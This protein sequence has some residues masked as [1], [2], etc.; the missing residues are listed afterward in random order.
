[1]IS[2]HPDNSVFTTF[3]FQAARHPWPMA[4]PYDAV[5][6][7]TTFSRRLRFM[8]TTRKS[9]AATVK[10][11][12][13][14]TSRKPAAD[15]ATRGTQARAVATRDTILR[16][17]IRVF[18]KDGFAGGRIES[19]SK[20]SRTHD[21]MIYYYFGSKERLFIE[22]LETIYE[23]MNEA[24]AALQ[25]DSDDPVAALT[26]IVHFHWQYYLDHP[27]LLTL[28]N[29]E[30]LHH[31]KHLKKSA[32]VSQLSSPAVGILDQVLRTGAKRGLFRNDLCARDLYIAIAS[33]GYFY[34]SNRYTLSAF[35]DA[36]LMDKEAL[37]NWREFITSIVLRSVS[38][39][40]QKGARNNIARRA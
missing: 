6:F 14:R 29:S 38:E 15:K 33:L 13:T 34:L 12:A 5:E 32:R 2:L 10:K 16:A 20:L 18:S 19:I 39:P 37:A 40:A 24:E 26:A 4:D 8:T 28:L 1:M 21:R 3:I 7:S 9:T 30:N 27:E 17:A 23:R 11:A 35:L 22:V 31:G 36:D 25:I